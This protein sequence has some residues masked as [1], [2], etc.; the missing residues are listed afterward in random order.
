MKW[1]QCRL[2]RCTYPENVDQKRPKSA[3]DQLHGEAD[4]KKE[5]KV[6][7]DVLAVGVEQRIC[8]VAPY[9]LMLCPVKY[10]FQQQVNMRR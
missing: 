9:F 7:N 3:V 1:L 2:D 6:D 4:E 10:F 8:E 5:G